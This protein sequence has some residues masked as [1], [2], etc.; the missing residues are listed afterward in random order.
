MKTITDQ[1]G[2]KALED[3]QVYTVKEKLVNGYELVGI[4]QKGTELSKENKYTF[5]YYDNLDSISIQV[6]NQEY[7]YELQATGGTG[8]TVYTIGGAAIMLAAFLLYGYRMR[9]KR[10]GGAGV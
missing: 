10:E 1:N 5:T 8:T 9:R 3:G 2:N 6:K 4:G 7:G